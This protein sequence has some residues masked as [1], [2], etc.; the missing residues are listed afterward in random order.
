MEVM[1]RQVEL[2]IVE[3]GRED[4]DQLTTCCKTGPQRLT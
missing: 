1:E 2:E 4:A 3:E